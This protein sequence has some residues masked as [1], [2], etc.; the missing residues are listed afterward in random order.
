MQGFLS[1]DGTS[2]ADFLDA[3]RTEV[4]G[5]GVERVDDR[6]VEV[7]R[8]LVLRLAAEEEGGEP[9]EPRLTRRAQAVRAAR[10]S[11]DGARSPSGVAAGL[12][13]PVAPPRL[14]GWVSRV[15]A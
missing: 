15:S 7:A 14:T 12:R 10:A 2:P 11:S 8:D 1:R 13:R 9:S 5:Y 4:L 3:A 6:V